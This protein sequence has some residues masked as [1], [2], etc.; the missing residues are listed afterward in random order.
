MQYISDIVHLTPEFGCL[1]NT[2]ARCLGCL[3]SATYLLVTPGLRIE[4]YTHFQLLLL[5]LP[6]NVELLNSEFHLELFLLMSGD[7]Q[8]PSR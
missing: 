1:E 3:F 6:E 7:H 8:P 5:L 4:G 2:Q